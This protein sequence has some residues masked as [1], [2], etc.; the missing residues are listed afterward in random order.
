[1][2]MF[3]IL[4][5]H[6]YRLSKAIIGGGSLRAELIHHPVSASSGPGE[7]G[8]RP[9]GRRFFPVLALVATLSSGLLTAQ[10]QPSATP[11]PTPGQQQPTSGE[12][13]GPTGDMG[14]IAVPKKKI[15]E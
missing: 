13:G 7:P 5:D 10:T 4:T 3:L 11:T 14:P 9:L 15:E 8:S 2:K 6:T 12:A 1:M